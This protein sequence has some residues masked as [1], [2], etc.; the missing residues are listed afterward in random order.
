MENERHTRKIYRL[1]EYDY[2][3]C[4]VYFITICTANR[5]KIFWNITPNEIEELSEFVTHPNNVPLSKEGKIAEDGIRKISIVYPMLS[6][7]EYVIMP[8]HLH[9]LIFIHREKEMSNV[10]TPTIS[11]VIQQFKGYVSKKV[12]RPMWQ[13]LFYDHVIRNQDDFEEHIKYIYQNPYKWFYEN[14]S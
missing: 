3:S 1:Q 11:R 13:K 10:K 6:V 12:G 2:S 9:M 8:D 4:G 5:E 14:K 7:E